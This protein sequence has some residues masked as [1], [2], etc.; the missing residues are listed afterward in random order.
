MHTG[1]LIGFAWGDVTTKSPH[2]AGPD[3]VVPSLMTV[4]HLRAP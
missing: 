4:I 3:V 2:A 1:R